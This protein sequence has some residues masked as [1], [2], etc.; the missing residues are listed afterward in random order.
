[1]V[2][3][4]KLRHSL[5]AVEYLHD[6]AIVSESHDEPIHHLLSNHFELLLLSDHLYE[7]LNPKCSTPATTLLTSPKQLSDLISSVV[8]E[9]LFSF[10]VLFPDLHNIKVEVQI[11]PNIKF[12]S[13]NRKYIIVNSTIRYVLSELIKNA[14]SATRSHLGDEEFASPVVSVFINPTNFDLVLSV[15]D[16]GGGLPSPPEELFRFGQSKTKYDRIEEQT[17]YAA[18][19]DPL[20]GVGVGLALSKIMLESQGLGSLKLFNRVPPDHGCVATI[21]LKN[22]PFPVSHVFKV[23]GVDDDTNTFESDIAAIV[24]R[25]SSSKVDSTTTKKNGKFA[26][27]SL[28]TILESQEQKE[29][30]YREVSL[31]SR[32]KF[33]L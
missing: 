6:I 11:E 29:K 3:D 19:R 33:Q 20:Q 5:T 23:I 12:T 8:D 26:S 10:S 27:I 22:D 14:I 7:L 25:N 21:N 24:E 4:V 32:V 16:S 18:A 17:S 2:N 28:T 31:D 30:I 9:S 15:C 13:S 1:M